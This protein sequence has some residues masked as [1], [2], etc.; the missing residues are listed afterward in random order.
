LTFTIALTLILDLLYLQTI[1][2]PK[3]LAVDQR[4]KDKAFFKISLIRNQN[5]VKTIFLRDF[6]QV[7]VWQIED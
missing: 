5:L 1:Y 7:F 6:M 2:I 4:L 3:I